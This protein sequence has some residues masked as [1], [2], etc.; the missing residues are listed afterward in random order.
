MAAVPLSGHGIL[1][2]LVCI[3][4][5]AGL[6]WVPVLGD[7]LTDTVSKHAPRVFPRIL[8][9]GLGLLTLGLVVHVRILDV[10]GGCLAGVVVLAVVLD[11][12]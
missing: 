7:R 11:N 2:G 4:V 6:L 12:Y 9:L 5:V 1:V 3:A 8:L 10:V